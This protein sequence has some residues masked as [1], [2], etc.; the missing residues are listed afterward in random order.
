MLDRGN[1]PCHGRAACLHRFHD[2]DKVR[3]M[4]L[5]YSYNQLQL[6]LNLGTQKKGQERNEAENIYRY[7]L[8]VKK[9]T[10]VSRSDED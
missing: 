2:D 6:I 7:R 4:D 8:S 3:D 1:R 10:Q 9:K 5:S